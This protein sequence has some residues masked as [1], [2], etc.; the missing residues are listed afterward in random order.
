[1]TSATDAVVSARREVKAVGVTTDA[2]CRLVA[3]PIRRVVLGE[4]PAGAEEL[5]VLGDD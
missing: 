5:D 4:V 1:L 2:N 3:T